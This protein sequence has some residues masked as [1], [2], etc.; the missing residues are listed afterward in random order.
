MQVAELMPESCRGI[1]RAVPFLTA[2][3]GIG[4]RV[5]LETVDSAITGC[6]SLYVWWYGPCHVQ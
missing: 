6:A 3:E 2:D 5:V 1:P 4:R